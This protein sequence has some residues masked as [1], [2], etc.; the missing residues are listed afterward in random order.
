MT[1]LGHYLDELHALGAELSI[2]STL[3]PVSPELTRLAD[4]SRDPSPHRAD[5]P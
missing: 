1:A 5:E 2:S 4:A 3:A